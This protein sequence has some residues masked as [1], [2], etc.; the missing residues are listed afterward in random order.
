MCMSNN[1]R[2]IKQTR[3]IY[4]GKNFVRYGEQYN[5]K[6]SVWSEGGIQLSDIGTKSVKENELSPRLGYTM[7]I[8]DN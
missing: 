5:I 1:G 7:L 6:K 2:D 8:I 3:H 4:R